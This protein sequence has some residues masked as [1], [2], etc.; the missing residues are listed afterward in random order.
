[1]GLRID[2]PVEGSVSG[3]LEVAPVHLNPHGVVH[4]AALFALLDTLMGAATQSVAPPGT[5]CST[6]DLHVRYLRPVERGPI[7]GLAKVVHRGGRLV[8]LAGDLRNEEGPV[9][10]AT[11][12]FALWPVEK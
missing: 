12:A 6:V 11:G 1:M 4:G 9:A 7:S 2:A 10:T 8:I 5:R 3:S